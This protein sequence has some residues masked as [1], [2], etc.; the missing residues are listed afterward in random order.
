MFFQSKLT[1]IKKSSLNHSAY[2]CVNIFQIILDPSASIYRWPKK[3]HAHILQI[4][5]QRKIR[6]SECSTIWFTI[7]FNIRF[8]IGL[9]IGLNIGFN[10][11]FNIGLNNELG[12]IVGLILGFNIRFNI[13]FKIGAQ[14]W[15]QYWVQY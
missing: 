14:Y 3:N 4:S 13:G 10:I 11:G 7:W 8:N 6:K 12:S 1:I 5:P 15:I 2:K 9:N